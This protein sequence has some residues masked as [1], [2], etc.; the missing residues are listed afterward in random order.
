MLA[1]RPAPEDIPNYQ[2]AVSILITILSA[3][4]ADTLIDQQHA[5]RAL[6]AL[7]QTLVTEIVVSVGTDHIIMDYVEALGLAVARHQSMLTDVTQSLLEVGSVALEHGHYLLAVASLERTLSIIEDHAQKPDEALAD[8]LGLTA[9]FWTS[10]VSGKE[11]SQSR[12]QRIEACLRDT[13]P[14]ALEKAK[15]HSQMTMRFDTADKLAEM[16]EGSKPK[17]IPRKKK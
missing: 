17:N 10:G 15:L 6:S 16:T 11:F 3:P 13:F 7:G 4:K 14:R 1:S 5:V 8:L 2:L 9:H 12:F